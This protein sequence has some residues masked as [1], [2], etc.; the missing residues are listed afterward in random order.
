MS[1]VTIKQAAERTGLSTSLLYQVCAERRL[2]HFRL[3]RAG[4]RGKILIEEDDLD[5]FMAAARVEAGEGAS[6]PLVHLK[7]RSPSSPRPADGPPAARAS[8]IPT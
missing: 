5:A 1:K 2:P 6:V 4:K 7:P 8:S 3:G